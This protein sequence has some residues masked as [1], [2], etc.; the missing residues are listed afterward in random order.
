MPATIFKIGL[1]ALVFYFLIKVFKSR[2]A[3]DS[4]IRGTGKKK[5][6]NT[7]GLEVKDAKFKDVDE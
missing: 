1:L 3:P 4:A 5:R 7:E 2:S 6:L